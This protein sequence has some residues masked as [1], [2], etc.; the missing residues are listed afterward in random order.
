M[1][2]NLAAVSLYKAI[3]SYRKYVLFVDTDIRDEISVKQVL[4][5]HNEYPTPW[6]ERVLDCFGPWIDTYMVFS[7]LW[8]RE[9]RGQYR[10][11]AMAFKEEKT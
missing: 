5:D 9:R 10:K 1:N 8:N 11:T 6:K 2:E 3:V 4:C 7:L